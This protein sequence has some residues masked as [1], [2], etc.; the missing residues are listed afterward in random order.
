MTIL[1]K[2]LSSHAESTGLLIDFTQ[3]VHRE[4][5]VHA[6]N[7]AAGLNG[8]GEVHVRRQ[9]NAGVVHGIELSGR[10]SP[11]LGRTQLLLHRVLA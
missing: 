6:L 1:D 7:R 8:L 5:N 9:I 2:R 4:V 3:E 10:E 11:S